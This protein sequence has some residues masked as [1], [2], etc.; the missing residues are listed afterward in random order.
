M[1]RGFTLLEVMV[2]IA[3]LSISLIVLLSYTG[4][5]MNTSL[6]AEQMT[7][8]TMLARQKMADIET[9]LNKGMRRNE[10][11]DEKSEE[12]TFEAP[13]EDFAWEME[14]RKVDLPAPVT[15]EP[16]S[17]QDVIGKNLTKQISNTVRELKLIVKW[18]EPEDEDTLEVVTHIVKLK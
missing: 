8:A 16:G 7:I 11:P 3:I 6:R 1:K 10:F 5:T 9:D 15:G 18:G 17:L 14:V 13:Y 12:G 4:N 2:A